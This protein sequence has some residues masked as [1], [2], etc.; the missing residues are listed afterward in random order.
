MKDF[1][2][3][4]NKSDFDAL[5]HLYNKKR[6][7]ENLSGSESYNYFPAFL[8]PKNQVKIYEYKK[9]VIPET[10]LD[11]EKLLKELEQSFVIEEIEP[12]KAKEEKGKILLYSKEGIYSLAPIKKIHNNF[13]DS[14]IFDQYI[15]PSLKKISKNFSQEAL[16][17]CSGDRSLKCVENQLNK[18]NCMLGFIVYPAAMEE[19]EYLAEKSHKI[20]DNSIYLQPRLLKGL[21]IYEL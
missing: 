13:P 15:Y 18:G 11:L 10:Q 3:A 16:S 8:I 9:G 5:L 21:F 4:D 7:E 6:K 19:I 17:Y 20:S 14:F 12:D 1:Y 2:L